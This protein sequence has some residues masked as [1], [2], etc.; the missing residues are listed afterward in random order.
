[1]QTVQ[2]EAEGILVPA[3]K[4]YHNLAILPLPRM[5]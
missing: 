4:R 1:M 5:R 2:P 3:D